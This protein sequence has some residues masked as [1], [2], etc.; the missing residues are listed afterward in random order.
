MTEKIWV[1]ED[2]PIRVSFNTK[3][4]A[5]YKGGRGILGSPMEAHLRLIAVRGRDQVEIP[6]ASHLKGRVAIE[7][8]EEALEFV[9]LFTSKGTHYLFPDGQ[10]IEPALAE[11]APGLGEFTKEYAQR[12]KLEPVRSRRKGD[13][14]EIERSLV[15]RAGTLLRATERVGK[16]GDYSLMK[17]VI[18][19]ESSPVSF[20]F[21]E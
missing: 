12:M 9:R 7:S 4:Y 8:T 6:G 21:Y 20:P 16:D 10:Y 14:F 3:G 2:E 19:D 11:N 1:L 17:A 5:F 15:D 13:G 18:I